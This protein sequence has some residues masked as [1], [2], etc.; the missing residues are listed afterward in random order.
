MDFHLFSEQEKAQ[1]NSLVNHPLQT[2]QWGEF[3]ELTGQKPIRAGL[4]KGKKIEKAFQILFKP[5]PKIPLTI[6]YLPKSELPDQRMLGVFKKISQQ[7]KAIF[8]KLEPDVVLRRWL[9]K[10][11]KVDKQSLLEKKIDLQELG[12]RPALKSL[13]DPYSFELDLAKS[14]TELM[15]NMH[16]K[17]RYNIRLAEKQGVAVKEES[18]EKGLKIFID[19]FQETLKRQ[20]FYMHS[21]EYFRKLWSILGKDKIARIFLARYK[22]GVLNAWMLFVWKERIFYPYGASSSEYRKLMAS[23]LICWEAIKYGKRIGCKKFDMWGSLGPDPD[24]KHPWYGF[25]RF[26]LG[27]GAD[28][29]QYVGSWDLVRD[30]FFY[31]SINLADNL[32]WKLLRLKRH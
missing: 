6:G 24:E 8:I 12:L 19:L 4:L 16:P 11:G 25:H 3:K 2:W 23:N 7:Q 26:K 21:P 20:K 15:E 29:V 14:E 17:T 9:I 30:K 28:L 10:K 31:Q 5:L 18:N 22:N 1:Y 32:R 13:F 27:Y